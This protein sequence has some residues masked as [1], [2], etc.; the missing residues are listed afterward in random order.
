L[1][2]LIAVDITCTG[3]WATTVITRILAVND[4][5]PCAISN[6]K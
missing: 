1:D 5:A 3:D 2:D 4:K 6:G